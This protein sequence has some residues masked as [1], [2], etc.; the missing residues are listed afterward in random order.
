MKQTDYGSIVR[1]HEM[2]I[3]QSNI[4]ELMPHRFLWRDRN[5]LGSLEV[6]RCSSLRIYRLFLWCL[7]ISYSLYIIG[8]FSLTWVYITLNHIRHSTRP[9]YLNLVSH[10][11]SFKQSVFVLTDFKRDFEHLNTSP[12]KEKKQLWNKSVGP[13]VFW[14]YPQCSCILVSLFLI[15][16]LIFNFF[17]KKP[18]HSV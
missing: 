16:F 13:V 8:C 6:A 11:K 12:A 7:E 15:L 3:I 18:W 17:L 5:G 2:S 4:W 1:W 9:Q 10:Y 14:V